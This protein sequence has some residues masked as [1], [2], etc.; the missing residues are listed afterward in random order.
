MVGPNIKPG[1]YVQ[2]VAA[3]SEDP[4]NNKIIQILREEASD[5]ETGDGATAEFSTVASGSNTGFRQVVSLEPDTGRLAWYKW[6]IFTGGVYE[7]Q[8]NAGS[9]RLGV[10]EA[11]AAANITMEK[12]PSFDPEDDY[13][14]YLV[15]DW[16]PAINCTNTTPN[17]ITPKVRFIGWKWDF[18]EIVGAQAAQILQS[19]KYTVA[20][21]GGVHQ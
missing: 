10:D 18:K 6:G 21:L 11:K 5:Y 12:S 16:W 3:S 8:V 17:T 4:M 7:M 14:F 13:A 2:L 19:G 9:S 15:T 20:T 1:F